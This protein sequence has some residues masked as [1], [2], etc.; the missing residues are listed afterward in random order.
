MNIA[1]HKRARTTPAVRREIQQ[2]EL[3]E[4][5]PAEKYGISRS[6]VRKWKYRDTAEDFS[7]RPH[8]LHATLTDA[9][10]AVVIELRGTLLLPIDDLLV[11]CVNSY[12]R[13]CNGAEIP[14]CRH[15]Q[16]D[17]MGVY[18]DPVL[19]DSGMRPLFSEESH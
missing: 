8:N 11:L 17:P 4:R 19:E 6:T 15:R 5:K 3:S 18:G 2:S 12:V 13:T 1:L 14:F 10:E 16:G 7:H 9:E